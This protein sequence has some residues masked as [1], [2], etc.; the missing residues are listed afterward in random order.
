MTSRAGYPK[1]VAAAAAMAL[2]LA[3]ALFGGTATAARE[4]DGSFA[5]AFRAT[6]ATLG[7]AIVSPAHWRGRDLARLAAVVGAGLA[8]ALADE[9]IRDG[10]LDRRTPGSGDVFSIVTKAGDGAYLGGF[11]AGL[12]A[13]GQVSGNDGLRKTAWLGVESYL[14]SS[15]FST[16]LKFAVGRA[17]PGAGE[18]SGRF[19]P[20]TTR[21]TYTAMPSGHATSAWAVATVIADR[22]DSLLVDVAC[23]GVAAL[24]SLSRIH[25]D[26]HWA[27]VVLVG[28]ALG[29]F[30]AKR[31]CALNR[32]GGGPRLSASFGPVRGGQAI[33]LSLAF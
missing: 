32:G 31:I 25:E 5:E 6:P 26:R 18:G 17:R 33:T 20:F 14:A 23:Y 7:R 21:S 24:A 1:R 12:F 27:S 2:V 22:T 28:S 16:V 3:G 29:Y 19:H 8:L 11:L 13:V 10:V 30:T 9:G 15:V 4:A